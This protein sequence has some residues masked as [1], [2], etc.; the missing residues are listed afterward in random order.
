MTGSDYDY[1]IV[2]GG[3]TGC[4]L[5][6]RLTEDPNVRVLV[7]EAG[8]HYRGIP[9]RVPAGIVGLYQQGKYHWPYR[10]EPEVH[11]A[12]QEL[13]YKM[14]RILGGSSAIN[15]LIWVRGN[16]ADYDGWAAEGCEGWS[17]DDV[18]PLFRRIERSDQAGDAILGSS[19]PIAVS[20]GDAYTSPLNA[21]FMEA[22]EEAGYPFNPNYNGPVQD[23][24]CVLQRNTGRGERCDVH[25]GYLKPALGRPNL[26][27]RCDTTVNQLIVA[28][29]RVTGVSFCAG[30]GQETV[31]PRREVIL[32]AGTL[33]SPQLLMLSGIGATD[34]LA[35]KGIKPVHALPGVG[36]NLHTHPIIRLSFSCTQP[37]SLLPWTQPP[38]KWLAGLQWL[39]ARKGAA[40]SNH[41]DTGLFVRTNPDLDRPDGIIT[42]VPL[43]LGR[44]YG[45]SDIHGFEIYMELLGA[46]SRG[47][48]TLRS[49]DPADLP[50]F[51]FNFLEDTRDTDAF[52]TGAKIMRSVVGQ[53]AF[54]AL[55]GKEL[56]PG[57]EVASDD[58]LDAWIRE[59][60]NVSHHLVGTCR[61][62][63][64][65]DPGTV[66]APDLKLVGL[67][68]LRIADASIMPIVPSANTHAAAIMIGEKAADLIRA[69]R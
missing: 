8:P 64:P 67:E 36:K 15:G 9:I 35:A 34:E 51:R 16:R 19:G 32:C 28:Q 11:A 12:G 29:G 69:E 58:D 6:S 4:V 38:R 46:K 21:A 7:L 65:D 49:D 61:M 27:V 2:G 57:S 68:G 50:S 39:L 26:T 20:R 60:A 62:G 47:A 43:V 22:A 59:T 3:T 24:V 1:V 17:Y 44:A 48:V 14:G 45:D 66:V 13:P 18:E 53:P 31:S 33:A 10:S 41:M 25:R 5:A 40:A 23:G 54:D 42:L 37:V 63:S 52:R 55:R 56:A 30:G